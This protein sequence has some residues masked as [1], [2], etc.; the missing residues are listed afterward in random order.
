MKILA[1][2]TKVPNNTPTINTSRGRRL[3]TQAEIDKQAKDLSDKAAGKPARDAERAAKQRDARVGDPLAAL[4]IVI[5]Q[6]N[7]MPG[8]KT[9]EFK[10]LV[11]KLTT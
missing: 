2:G 4:R 9:S 11:G 7:T 3:M 10:A 8:T 1:D 6:I 5:E